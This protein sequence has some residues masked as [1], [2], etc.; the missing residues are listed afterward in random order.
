VKRNH[1]SILS[2]LHRPLL[3]RAQPDRKESNIA[4]REYEIIALVNSTR[5]DRAN[6]SPLTLPELGLDAGAAF[7]GLIG[8]AEAA[9]PSVR[10][11][12][13]ES[14]LVAE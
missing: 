4:Y 6:A 13:S 8:R 3:Y 1:R 11:A 9:R 5:S 12:M 14:R 10:H 2:D 7:A